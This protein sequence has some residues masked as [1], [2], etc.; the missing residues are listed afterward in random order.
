MKAGNESYFLA[1][2]HD[3]GAGLSLEEPFLTKDIDKDWRY[4]SLVHRLLDSW[5]LALDY[6]LRLL[7]LS[8]ALGDGMSSTEGAHDRQLV[9]VFFLLHFDRFQHLDLVVSIEPVSRFYL[10][11]GCAKFAHPAQI[12]IQLGSQFLHCSLRH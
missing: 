10:H 3:L 5:D 7:S 4:F 8:L 9:L 12:L 11:S 1:L 6:I 2:Q